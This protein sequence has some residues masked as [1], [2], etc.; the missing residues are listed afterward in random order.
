MPSCHYT[1][2]H[3]KKSYM[4]NPTSRSGCWRPYIPQLGTPNGC[5]VG[6]RNEREN[7]YIIHSAKRLADPEAAYKSHHP[8]SS[9]TKCSLTGVGIPT[10]NTQEDETSTKRCFVYQ[11]AV[12]LGSGCV[13]NRDVKVY[14][15]RPQQG[16]IHEETRDQEVRGVRRWT[17][18]LLVPPDNLTTGLLPVVDY[19]LESIQ[20]N[21]CGGSRNVS[22]LG[23]GLQPLP[24]DPVV[25]IDEPLEEPVTHYKRV[26][27]IKSNSE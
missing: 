14:S 2:R 23:A 27:G 3:K 7:F 1:I 26:Y 17:S 5:R 22:S 6:I 11:D 18:T 4:K 25:V 16:R 15:T 19:D 9:A 12:S 8:E 13:P 20:R 10:E 24:E 21:R